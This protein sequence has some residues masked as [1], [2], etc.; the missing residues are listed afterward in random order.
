LSA[1]RL[2]WQSGPGHLCDFS[3]PWA[4]GVD[5]NVRRNETACCVDASDMV[6]LNRDPANLSAKP[7][8]CAQLTRL[9]HEAH[10]HAVRIDETIGL[11][12]G[13]SNDVVDSKLRNKL[14]DILTSD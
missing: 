6:V 3:S 12:K 8:S 1:Q 4:S 2:D 13:A 7:K 11:T 5:D 9:K 10:H 14:R